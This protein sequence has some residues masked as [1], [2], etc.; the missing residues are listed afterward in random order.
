MAVYDK[1][2]TDALAHIRQS[3]AATQA[4][5]LRAGGRRDFVL[6]KAPETP[7]ARP[8]TLSW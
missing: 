8:R 7:N 5:G 4:Q 3:H 2:L 1:L 6:P